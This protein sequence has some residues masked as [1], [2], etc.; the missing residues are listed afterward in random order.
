MGQ[1]M[2]HLEK[3]NE[4]EIIIVIKLRGKILLFHFCPLIVIQTFLFTFYYIT[5]L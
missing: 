1:L 3:N 5:V 2:S 4:I